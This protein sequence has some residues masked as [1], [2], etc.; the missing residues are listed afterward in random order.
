M[1]KAAFRDARRDG[2]TRAERACAAAGAEPRPA[3]GE[4][5]LDLDAGRAVWETGH[6]AHAAWWNLLTGHSQLLDRARTR[7]AVFLLLRQG[8]DG[9]L[10]TKPLASADFELLEGSARGESGTTLA[11][12]KGLSPSALHDLQRKLLKRIGL[13]SRAELLWFCREHDGLGPPS[14]LQ[15]T[16]WPAFGDDVV[17]L[18][19]AMR[20]SQLVIPLTYTQQAIVLALLDGKSNIAIARSRQR[21]PCTIANQV[22]SIRDMLGARNRYD[23]ILRSRDWAPTAPL[24]DQLPS[25]V[26]RRFTD[27]C[28]GRRPPARGTY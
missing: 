5:W 11:T 17:I 22:T 20:P 15:A 14:S 16:R 8:T 9:E 12:S 21:S 19:A 18:A 13:A 23:L 7:D 10:V 27:R 1:I 6:V 28:R 3:T 26:V 24:P 2:T 25:S 4:P